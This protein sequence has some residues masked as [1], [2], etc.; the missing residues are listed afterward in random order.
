MT[1]FVSQGKQY[2]N[3][4]GMGDTN[5]CFYIGIYLYMNYLSYIVNLNKDY[6]L[7]VLAK[8]VCE[9]FAQLIGKIADI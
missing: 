4:T 9:F 6:P 1:L 3:T 2:Q 7:R 8:I 5:Q